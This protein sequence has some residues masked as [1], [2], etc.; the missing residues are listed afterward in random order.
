[1]SYSKYAMSASIGLILVIAA[2][3][4]HAD[5]TRTTAPAH[6]GVKAGV[7]VVTWGG[8]DADNDFLSTD[9]KLG[10]SLA[11]FVNLGID[12]LVSLDWKPWRLMLQSEVLYTTKGAGIEIDTARGAYRLSYLEVTML[13]RFEYAVPG[14]KF[15]PYALVGPSIGLL[16]SGEIENS[17]G[18]VTDIK[19]D[20]T[21]T[22]LG[23]VLGIGADVPIS[24][25]GLL[26]LEL[27]AELG[28][29]SID[30]QGGGDDVKNRAYLLMV[31]YQY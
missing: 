19:D 9:G 24:V 14:K 15:S 13:P 29:T 21:S 11:G 18:D 16:L 20:F 28:L 30:G 23:L 4:A 31:G 5:A 8:A 26:V 7:G 6:L 25:Y 1:M 3:V 12:E 22:D 27:R 10:L 17:Q 2:Q